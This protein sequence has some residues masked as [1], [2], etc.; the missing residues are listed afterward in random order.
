MNYL[1]RAAA[2]TQAQAMRSVLQRDHP[3]ADQRLGVGPLADLRHWPDLQV[4]DVPEDPSGGGC[5]VSGAYFAGTPAVLAI[6]TSASLAR[7]DITALH[8]LGHHLQQ[9]RVELTDVLLAQPDGG[10]VWRTRPATPS[11]PTS[12]CRTRSPISTSPPQ[13]P[14]PTPRS[15][16]GDLATRPHLRPRRSTVMRL[17]EGNR[18]DGA[19]RAFDRHLTLNVP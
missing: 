18:N 11:P 15:R 19:Q 5:S 10:T 12:C 6:A 3:G 4:R 17:P 9:T 13:A 7:R 2:R 1:P 8:E 14:P 16:S